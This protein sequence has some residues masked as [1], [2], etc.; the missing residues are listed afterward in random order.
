MAVGGTNGLHQ[1]RQRR[2][3]KLPREINIA[4]TGNVATSTVARCSQESG[5]LMVALYEGTG[6]PIW[7]DPMLDEL[8]ASLVVSRSVGAPA[9]GR[10]STATAA[11]LEV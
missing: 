10:L 2:Q 9:L 4:S 5:P 1:R 3:S 7:V 6:P 11:S 8:I